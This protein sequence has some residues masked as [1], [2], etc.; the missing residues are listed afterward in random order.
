MIEEKIQRRVV[1]WERIEV[2]YRAGVLSI[3]E[4]ADRHKIS[5][6]AIRLYAKGTKKRL[7]WE[8][9]LGE[10]VKAKASEI[11]RTDILRGTL[12][13]ET[14]TER[15]VIDATANVVANVQIGHRKDIAALRAK[16]STYQEELETCGEEFGKRVSILKML[17][18][19][20][21]T[22]IASERE[23]YGIDG[24]SGDDTDIESAIKKLINVQG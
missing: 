22:L 24:K 20:Q 11:L 2:E 14:A 21:K 7:A 23:A 1:D 17:A 3:R 4:I 10:K 12:R 5:D 16:A 19:T 15:E 18:D 6:T 9:D 13:T 8:R